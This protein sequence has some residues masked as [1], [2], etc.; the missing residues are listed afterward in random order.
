M[1]DPL[2]G[3]YFGETCQLGQEVLMSGT[4]RLADHLQPERRWPY[5]LRWNQHTGK[6]H[7]QS[8]QL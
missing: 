7:E 2:I 6:V 8:V 1:I 4:A 3:A 5:S